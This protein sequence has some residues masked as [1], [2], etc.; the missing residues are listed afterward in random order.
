MARKTGDPIDAV[1]GGNL[2]RIRK[3][4]GL[5]QS[6]IA[7]ALGVSFQ[8]VQKYE[9]GSNRI[10]ASVLYD[11]S[12]ALGVSMEDF[13]KGA[14][15]VKRDTITLQAT[16]RVYPTGDLARVKNA[17]VRR[18]LESLIKSVSSEVDDPDG[19]VSAPQ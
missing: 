13:F 8:Q 11:L 19:F 4:K 5:S 2:T 7:E 14:E 18:A 16:G 17:G 1:V 10:S 9:K 15:T 3:T 6:A 12:Q